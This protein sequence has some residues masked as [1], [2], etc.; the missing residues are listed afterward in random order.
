MAGCEYSRSAQDR[1]IGESWVLDRRSIY[2]VSRRR[3]ASVEQ[4]TFRFIAVM[5]KL[6]STGPTASTASPTSTSTKT[7]KITGKSNKKKQKG[8]NGKKKGTTSTKKS[9]QVRDDSLEGDDADGTSGRDDVSPGNRDMFDLAE[10]LR[11][12]GAPRNGADGKAFRNELLKM[13]TDAWE[14]QATL[15]QEPARYGP[16]R[17]AIVPSQSLRDRSSSS[18]LRD[19]A[20]RTSELSERNSSGREEYQLTVLKFIQ[21]LY[22]TMTS[23]PTT[24]R[25]PAGI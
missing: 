1:G 25:L 11:D 5:P 19:I 22:T 24:G 3:R 20:D 6:R 18:E 2:R 13:L 9:N 14:V 12:A 4:D 7:A 16:T 15:L 17:S 21:Y 10:R 23:L 8:K